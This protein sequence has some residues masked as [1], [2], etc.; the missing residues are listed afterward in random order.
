VVIASG[1]L[2]C[3]LGGVLGDRGDRAKLTIGMML[4]SATCSLLIGVS[5][6]ISL[7]LVVVVGI[8]WGISV[9]GDS[10]QFSTLVTERADQRYVG[11]A[12]T[13]Q[14]AFGFTL[15]VATIWL[16]PRFVD[17]VGWE[18]G[19]ALLAPGPLL[20]SLAMSRLRR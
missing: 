11:T 10:A 3:W 16:I 19:F 20:G 5:A 17:T 9:V 4:T 8:A 13:L 14:L 12:L 2:G 6:E 1:A 15:T 18:W 7:L